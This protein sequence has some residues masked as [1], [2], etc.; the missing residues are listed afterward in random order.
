M[1]KPLVTVSDQAFFAAS[2]EKELTGD[3]H[4]QLTQGKEIG[5]SQQNWKNESTDTFN[6]EWKNYDGTT[7][8]GK[9]RTSTAHYF[10][11][12]ADREIDNDM[13]AR[14]R[15]QNYFSSISSSSSNFD[16]QICPRIS[17]RGCVRPS[18]RS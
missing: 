9:T 16:F 13:T 8:R 17:I 1:A 3:C 2:I 4:F 6:M 12:V 14:S 5:L 11:P 7:P 15:E 18:A 10:Q